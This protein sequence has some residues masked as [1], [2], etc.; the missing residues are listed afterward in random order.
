M[1]QS[2]RFEE[3]WDTYMPIGNPEAESGPMVGDHPR[4]LSPWSDGD[5]AQI[6]AALAMTPDRLWTLVEVDGQQLVIDG[7]AYV[8]REGYFVA[9]RPCPPELQGRFEVTVDGLDPDQEF[10]P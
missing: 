1:T 4:L 9:E 10:S 8:N 5:R 7:F 6:D 3:W 2:M